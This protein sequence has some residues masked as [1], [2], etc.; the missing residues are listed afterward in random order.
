MALSLTSYGQ[1]E[2]PLLARGR[3]RLETISLSPRPLL[4]RFPLLARGRDRLET[5][6]AACNL[7]LLLCSPT[8]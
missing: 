1:V 6:P 5:L 2:D 3:D 4:M 7:A 8:R